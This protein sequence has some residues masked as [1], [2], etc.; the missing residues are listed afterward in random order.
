MPKR[1]RSGVVSRPVR[2]VA[3]TSVKGGRSR[4]QRPRGRALPDHDVEAEVLERRIEDL[5]DRAVQPVDLIHE[6]H[7]P[8]LEPREDRGQVALAL[9]RWARHRA[10]ADTSSSRRM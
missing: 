3:P 10:D 1:S 2:V 7:V 6:Q 5:L 8:R 9:E 4:R